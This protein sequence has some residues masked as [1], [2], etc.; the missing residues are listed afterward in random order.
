MKRLNL[1]VILLLVILIGVGTVFYID[2]YEK[3]TEIT[4]KKPDLKNQTLALEKQ[5]SNT[6]ED[7]S[8]LLELGLL[9]QKQNNYIKAKE[10]Y[11]DVV[12]KSPNESLGWQRLGNV[13][14]YLGE[15]KKAVNAREKYVKLNEAKPTGYFYLSQN[16]I[17]ID[18]EKAL[19][20]G[21]KAIQ[22][23]EKQDSKDENIDFLFEY[24]KSLKTANASTQN[25]ISFVESDY[26]TFSEI[27]LA[28]IKKYLSDFSGTEEEKEQLTDLKKQTESLVSKQ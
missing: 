10:V 8:V 9:Y 3:K 22:E 28:L 23:A 12:G 6:P 26:I 15:F 17:I 25:F 4:A 13:Y 27:K 1:Y 20:A 21:E 16:L 7:M 11:L 14:T 18:I 5:V 19:T 2:S 24:V